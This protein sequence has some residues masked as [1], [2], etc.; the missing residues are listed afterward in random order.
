MLIFQ[1]SF[2]GETSGSGAKC[3]LFFLATFG[4]GNLLYNI[5]FPLFVALTFPLFKHW[6]NSL[7]KKKL[8]ESFEVDG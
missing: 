7:K 5:S 2:G 6:L 4:V 3:R 8:S 1:M